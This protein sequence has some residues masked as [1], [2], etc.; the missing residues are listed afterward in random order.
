MRTSIEASAHH[1]HR[2]L[3]LKDTRLQE[4]ER[5]VKVI[6]N[7]FKNFRFDV[8]SGSKKRSE[9]ERDRSRAVHPE[10]NQCFLRARSLSLSLSLVRCI[11]VN[12]ISPRARAFVRTRSWHGIQKGSASAPRIYPRRSTL[13]SIRH[14]TKKGYN[15]TDA[16]AR[17]DSWTPIQRRGVSLCRYVCLCSSRGWNRGNIFQR[18]FQREWQVYRNQWGRESA[19][20]S[21]IIVDGRLELLD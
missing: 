3:I 13:P 6:D 10:N 14:A 20:L 4:R 9:R 17:V 2:R 15:K 18:F 19:R 21:A 7:R 5:V 1:S 8:R 11:A 16:R 12:W